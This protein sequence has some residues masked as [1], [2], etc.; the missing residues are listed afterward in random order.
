MKI[1]SQDK[2]FLLKL[3]MLIAVLYA[4]LLGI[5]SLTVYTNFF[6]THKVQTFVPFMNLKADF[7]GAIIPFFVG[8]VFSGLYISLRIDT[9]L[10]EVLL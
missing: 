2:A 3:L 5:Y 10:G 1:T 6:D 9:N 8:L 4:S 7:F